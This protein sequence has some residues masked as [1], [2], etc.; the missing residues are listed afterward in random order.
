MVGVG[1]LADSSTVPASILASQMITAAV[2]PLRAAILAHQ[3]PALASL[4][5]RPEWPGSSRKFLINSCK[6]PE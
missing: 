5:S 1:I 3:R 2:T 6:P 4:L